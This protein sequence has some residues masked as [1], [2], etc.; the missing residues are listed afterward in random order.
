MSTRTI[1]CGQS[2]VNID[3]LKKK[4]K[5]KMSEKR[6]YDYQT[7]YLTLRWG[8]TEITRHDVAATGLIENNWPIVYARLGTRNGHKFLI[9]R[10]MRKRG[11]AIMSIRGWPR[12]SED[13]L[14][15]RWMGEL[16]ISII[17]NER[18]SL[19]PLLILWRSTRH[20]IL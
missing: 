10:R 16:S 6:L 13:E 1:V 2:F 5:K 8:K 18:M 12:W 14:K 4:K 9:T 17:F 3:R 20:E 7:E 11:C 15:I 19:F